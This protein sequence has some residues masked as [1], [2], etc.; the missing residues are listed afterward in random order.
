MALKC[1]SCNVSFHPQLRSQW[2]GF[3]KGKFDAI[4]VYYQMCP[5]CDEPVIG[6]KEVKSTEFP[7]STQGEGVI[8]MIPHHT[9]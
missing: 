6:F 3:K 2:V 1:P 5:E 9:K 4:Y 8:L 7:F